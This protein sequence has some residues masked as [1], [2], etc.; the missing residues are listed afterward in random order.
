MKRVGCTPQP[1]FGPFHHF[2]AKRLCDCLMSKTDAKKRNSC[3][4]RRSDERHQRIHPAMIFIN[5]RSRTGHDIAI[6]GVDLSGNT[7]SEPGKFPALSSVGLP[8]GSA[9]DQT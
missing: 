1:A 3:F 7:P 9:A 5:A 2:T 4:M 8:A 6:T